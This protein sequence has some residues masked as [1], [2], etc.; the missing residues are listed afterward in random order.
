[1][2][3]ADD[4]P[5]EHRRTRAIPADELVKLLQ[6][7]SAVFWSLPLIL[8]L[9]L[10][11]FFVQRQDLLPYH[12]LFLI[13]SFGLMAFGAWKLLGVKAP[14]QCW[15]RRTRRT[16]ITAAVGA[17]FSMF[18][19]W[20]RIA[21][22]SLLLLLNV[23]GF[24]LSGVALLTVL[25][26]ALAELARRLDEQTLRSDFHAA[27]YMSLALGITPLAG[28]AISGL[29]MMFRPARID[30]PA[31]FV[32]LAAHFSEFMAAK[33]R[34]TEVGLLILGLFPVAVLLMGIW[35]LKTH[36]LRMIKEK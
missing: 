6:G 34:L 21:P 25:A 14:G 1:M 9:G 20:W 18:V 17:Y 35:K 11:A 3:T 22:D 29:V 23:L 28:I 36:V 12:N 31:T 19:I 5:T 2:T 33:H 10:S 24:Y 8:L 4:Q 7:L 30:E 15:R 32:Q 26:T 16:M 27:I 13:L